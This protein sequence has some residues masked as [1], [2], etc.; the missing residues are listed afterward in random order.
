MGRPALDIGTHGKVRTYAAGDVFRS[1]CYVRDFDGVVRECER[2]GRSRAAAERALSTALRDR[3]RID[4]HAEVTADTKFAAVAELWFADFQRKDR[5][6]NTLQA[7]RD[8]LDKQILPA[9]GSV[10]VRELSVGLV[11]RHLRAVEAK[12]GAGLAK[13]TKTVLGQVCGLA[14]RH[15]ALTGNPVRDTSPIS[16]KP[17]KAPRAFTEEQGLQLLAFLTYDDQAIARDI[18]AFVATM[19]A[20]GMRIGEACGVLWRSVDLDAGKLTVEATVI[21]LKGQGLW[22]KPEPKTASSNRTLKLPDWCVAMLSLRRDTFEATPERPV[23]PSPRGMLRDPSNTAADLKDAFQLA[24]FEWATSHVLRKTVAS[25]LDASG[26]SARDIADQL[27]HARPSITMDR[28][29]GRKTV[30][31]HNAKVLEAFG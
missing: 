28:Y 24:G 23:F 3:A 1:R 29:M 22:R 8:R 19:L 30:T 9:L 26:R 11:D 13:Q 27:G 15:D 12:H 17:K 7:Y 6:P 2:T 25:L 20:T 14:V 5:S 31:S 21:R 16:T 4:A 10:R 18:P